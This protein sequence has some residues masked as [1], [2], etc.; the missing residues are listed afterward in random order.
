VADA[1]LTQ[2]IWLER[3]PDLVRAYA[4]LRDLRLGEPCIAG[5]AVETVL[6]LLETA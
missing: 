5:A 1:G 4:E 6:W 2:A 3:V